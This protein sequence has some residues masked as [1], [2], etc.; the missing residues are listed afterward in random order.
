MTN[1]KMQE[2]IQFRQ[3]DGIHNEM[4]LSLKI[5][6]CLQNWYGRALRRLV[7]AKQLESE[8]L[9][10]KLM[11]CKMSEADT[12]LYMSDVEDSDF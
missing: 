3:L 4:A 2:K 1:K 11:A 8:L 5:A 7:H 10:L 12:E 6:L 9:L